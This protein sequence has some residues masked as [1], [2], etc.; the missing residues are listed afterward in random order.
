MLTFGKLLVL[1]TMKKRP[2]N[3]YFLRKQLS[4][5]YWQHRHL[6]ENYRMGDDMA[7]YLR[8]MS[9][10][11]SGLVALPLPET[12]SGQVV[13]IYQSNSILLSRLSDLIQQQRAEEIFAMGTS[14]SGFID[15]LYSSLNNPLHNKRTRLWI[16]GAVVLL[17]CVAAAFLAPTLKKQYANELS[18]QNLA[19]NE[20]S[21]KQQTIDDLLKLKEALEKYHSAH[22]AYPASSGGFDAVVAAFGESKEEWIPGL[23]PAFIDRLP[24]D[25]RKSKDPRQQYMYRSDGKDY[26]LIAH[27]PVGMNEAVEKHPE[28]V[29]P[30]RPSWALGVWSEA[31]TNW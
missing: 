3:L 27:N 10:I 16:G 7:N 30:A 25:P 28:L 6:N 15:Q 5:L 26:K 1:I 23:A 13:S 4:E 19:M 22:N 8:G 18:T 2:Y 17:I 14:I 21:Y 29:D 31:A 11:H 20:E 9:E 12:S 24:K